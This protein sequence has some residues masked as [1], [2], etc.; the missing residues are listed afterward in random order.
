MNGGS[1]NDHLCLVDS[2]DSSLQL[3]VVMPPP[4]PTIHQFILPVLFAFAHAVRG[5]S[6]VLPGE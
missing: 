1:R 6:L 5:H 3:V 4:P 2:T